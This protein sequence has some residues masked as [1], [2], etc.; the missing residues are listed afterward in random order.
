[1][2]TPPSCVGG[3][4]QTCM[5]GMTMAMEVCG[6]GV[7]DNCNGQVDED[8]DLDG[9]GYTTCGGDCCDSG[10]VC[11]HPESVNPGAFDVPGDGI[12][13]N[14]DGHVDLVTHCDSG[15]H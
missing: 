14:C 4:P 2:R 7:D 6:N 13:N 8:V 10:T 1:L 15:L 12:D 5:P 11:A 9:D 3:V